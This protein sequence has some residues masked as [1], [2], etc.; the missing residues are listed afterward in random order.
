MIHNVLI[1][2]VQGLLGSRVSSVL[3]EK[4]Y[5]I[6]GI[7]RR[8]ILPSKS[9]FSYLYLDLAS[10]WS[11]D[12]LPER[13]DAVIHLAQSANFR[14]FPGNALDV[15]RVNI[16][17][18]A[19]L[20]DYA[21]QVGVKKFIYASSG[22]IYGNSCHAFKENAPIVPPGNLGFYLGSKACGEILVQSYA[23]IFKV[24]VVRPFFIYGPGQR[25]DMLIPRLFSSIAT[26][27]SVT[28]QGER[29]IRI[30]PVHV[31]D[32]AAAIAAALNLDES[33][34]FNIAGPEVL[35]VRDICE[36]M[37]HYLGVEPVFEKR[38]GESS[39][40]IA[41]ISAMRISLHNPFRRLNEYLGDVKL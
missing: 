4:G 25:C 27:K 29:G 36:G 34:T 30:N 8:N 22:G 32:A 19:R 24:V 20:L 37:A 35:S 31:D 5:V 39:D 40:L 33:A 14:D 1:T 12:D 41:D 16:D 6:H 2:G 9:S 17:S 10:N 15:F 18:T 21:T 3:L 38:P 11:F 23:S 26:G 13:C 7:T 28:L